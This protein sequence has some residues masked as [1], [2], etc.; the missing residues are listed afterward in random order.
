MHS[1]RPGTAEM[2]KAFELTFS[3]GST[4]HAIQVDRG[5]DLSAALHELDFHR[6]F[7]TLVLVGGA[8]GLGKAELDSLRPLF[9]E[10]LAPLAAT[11][12]AA[13]VDGGTDT[14]V[15]RLMG[16]ARA[17]TN[18][19]FALVGVVAIGMVTLPDT[20]LPALDTAL[21][22][23]HHT[24]FV[25][26][27]GSQWG[28]ESPWL[29]R[30]AGTLAQGAPSVTVLVNGGK[31]AWQD[32]LQSVKARRPVIVVGGSGRTADLLAGALRGEIADERARE[33]SA[34]GLLRAVDLKASADTLT[35]TIEQS[36][37]LND[38]GA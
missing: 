16:Q 31:T 15:M 25:L 14:G 37:L 35:R 29:S 11:L 5:A 21:L 38:L 32:V 22:E 8:G 12:G 10:V 2:K 17:E 6:S 13:V 33:L 26:V 30:V 1:H 28:D 24:H 18:A 23:S 19:T 7:R 3:N 36:L 34:S 4:T 27:P 9:I 20:Q